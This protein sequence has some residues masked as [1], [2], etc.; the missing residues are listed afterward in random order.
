MKNYKFKDGSHIKN[1]SAEIVGKRLDYL[2]EKHNYLTPE[3]VVTDAKNK[4]SELHPIF[5]WNDKKAAAEHRKAQA[6]ALIRSIVVTIESDNN[7]EKTE[8]DIRVFHNVR[9]DKGIFEKGETSRYLTITDA[10]NSPEATDFLLKKA[11]NDMVAFKNKYSN[12][13]QLKP[14][15]EKLDEIISVL[16]E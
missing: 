7:K 13:I 2:Y 5:E 4:E 1:V 6:R 15:L 10:L 3:I 8:T 12:L 14:Y 16:E 11:Y 9:G